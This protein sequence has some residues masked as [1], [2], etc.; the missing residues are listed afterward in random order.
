MASVEIKERAD[1]EK[2]RLFLSNDCKAG[3]ALIGDEIVS[4]FNAADSP[5]RSVSLSMIRLAVE[6][7]GRRLDAFDIYLPHIYARNGF[8]V[9]GRGRW[10]DAY[11]PTPRRG[12]PVS[13]WA[14][15]FARAPPVFPV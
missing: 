3:F 6:L 2:A 9:V 4:V 5:H 7:G 14:T 12:R 15:P 1:Y 13:S 10:D 8:R 11:E